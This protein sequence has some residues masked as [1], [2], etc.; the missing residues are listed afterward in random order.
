MC[1]GIILSTYPALN[2]RLGGSIR[3][4]ISIGWYALSQMKCRDWGRI[5]IEINKSIQ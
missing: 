2:K 5:L 4:K 3:L 1:V